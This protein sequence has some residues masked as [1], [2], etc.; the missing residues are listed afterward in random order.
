[1]AGVSENYG[2]A[3]GVATDDFIE[4]EH[5]NR[6]AATL[7]RVLGNVLKKMMAQGACSGWGLTL[8]GMVTAG[9]GLVGGCWCHSL[10]DQP[11]AGL[12]AGVTNY[13][14]GRVAAEGP[15]DGA[16]AFFG[17][18]SATKPA[19]AVLLGAVEVDG[20]GAV[21]A[22]HEDVAGVDRNCLRLEIGRLTGSGLVTD[23]APGAEVTAQVGHE[24]MLVPGAIEFSGS[25]GFSFV[26]EETYRGDGFAVTAKND[27]AVAADFSYS[28]ARRGL[29][30]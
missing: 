12:T 18:V 24:E 15:T 13:V 17:Q 27:G 5:H 1:M 7:D 23:V 30:G 3:V 11:V 26:L 19:G 29:V 25:E 21:S 22:V 9:E 6:V 16:V 28:W 2:L 4:P 14:F 10:E 20:T 8:A